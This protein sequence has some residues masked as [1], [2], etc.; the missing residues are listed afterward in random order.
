MNSSLRQILSTGNVSDLVDWMRK[1]DKVQTTVVD[2]INEYGV[3]DKVNDAVSQLQ[4]T[5]SVP[6]LQT[7]LTLLGNFVPLL[8]NV[9]NLFNIRNQVCNSLVTEIRNNQLTFRKTHWQLSFIRVTESR[10]KKKT[11]FMTL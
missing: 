5:I 7:A 6:S 1:Y 8:V 10:S 4:S 2:K 9:L 11:R 3:Q